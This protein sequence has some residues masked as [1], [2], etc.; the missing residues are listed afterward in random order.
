MTLNIVDEYI[1]VNGEIRNL[2]LILPNIRWD[3]LD[4]PEW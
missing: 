1:C 3:V 2:K 4:C